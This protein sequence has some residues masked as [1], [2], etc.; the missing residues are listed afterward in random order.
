[1][2]HFFRSKVLG[3]LLGD[4]CRLYYGLFFLFCIHSIKYKVGG[5]ESGPALTRCL[6]LHRSVGGTLILPAG[7]TEPRITYQQ[8]A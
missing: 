3:Y 5:K 7:V 2:L 4:F 6:T 1:M 8:Q